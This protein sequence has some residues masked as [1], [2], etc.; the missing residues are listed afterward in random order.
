MKQAMWVIWPAFLVAGA[1]ELLVFSVVDPADLNSLSHLMWSRDAYYSIAFFV[2]WAV[3]AVASA[4][5]LW[6][7]AG[8]SRSESQQGPEAELRHHTP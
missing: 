3:V 5:T 6:L 4:L 8:E 1:L 2:F 7:S